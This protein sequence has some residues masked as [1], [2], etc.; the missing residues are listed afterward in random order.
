MLSDCHLT[1]CIHIKWEK[2]INFPQTDGSYSDGKVT[3]LDIQEATGVQQLPF[4]PFCITS[5]CG[6]HH[7]FSFGHSFCS[8]KHTINSTMFFLVTVLLTGLILSSWQHLTHDGLGLVGN[9]VSAYKLLFLRT[10][11]FPP[12]R[13]MYITTHIV[14]NLTNI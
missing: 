3:V 10:S 14:G 9:C 5:N 13:Q 12:S 7:S 4:L 8:L 6:Y 11:L 2:K 1:C